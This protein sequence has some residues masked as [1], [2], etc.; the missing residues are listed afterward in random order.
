MPNF[1]YTGANG[2]QQ[3]PYSLEELQELANQ[4]IITPNTQL[5][6]ETGHKGLARQIPGLTFNTTAPH[7]PTNG[8]KKG[9]GSFVQ[10]VAESF[11][12]EPESTPLLSRFTY[13]F[14]AVIVGILGVHEFY[15]RRFGKGAIHLACLAP[16]ILVFIFSIITTLLGTLGIQIK[17]DWFD[18]GTFS[19][20][21]VQRS[22]GVSYLCFCVLPLVSYV[23]A[24]IDVVFVTKDGIG[25]EFERF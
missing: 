17:V 13:I 11:E 4:G 10:K 19:P 18:P 8:G 3:G 25:R 12:S 16:W 15:A 23:K 5:Q 21:G 7:P 24:L 22:I 20:Q 6:T 1:I 2:Q 9:I 14:L